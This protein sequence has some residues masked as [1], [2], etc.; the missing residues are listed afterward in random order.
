MSWIRWLRKNNT[1]VMAVVVIVLM[2]AFI[3]GSSL[4]Y[5]LRGRGGWNKPLAYY[6]ENNKITP[7]DQNVARQEL[8]ILRALRAPALLQSQD[9][10]GILLGELLFAESRGSPAVINYV[11]R[12]ARTNQ[13]RIS[14]RQIY[15]IYGRTMP[16]DMYWLLLKNE[17][18]LAGMHLPSKDVAELMGRVIPHL[19]EGKT[20]S[21]VMTALVNQFGAAEQEILGTLGKLLAVLQYAYVACSMEDVTD[22][23]TRHVA[24]YEGET[25]DAEFVRFDP[26]LFAESGYSPSEQDI[27]AQFDKHKNYF[28]GEVS[29]ENP[30]GF[31]YKLPD[32]I[33]LEYIAVKLDDVLPRIAVPTEEESEEYY[34]KNRDR[35]FTEQVSEDPN[36]P[37]SPKVKRTKGYAEVAGSISQ[38]LLRDRVNTKAEQILQDARGLT[39]AALAGATVEDAN[40]TVE[41]LKKLAGDYGKA[42][43]QVSLKHGVKVYSG[44][45]GLLSAV[46][47][48]MDE[49]LSKL[50][51][52]TLGYNPV[53]LSQIIFS[54]EG[55]EQ[56]HPRPLFVQKTRMYESIGPA[57][58]P[59]GQLKKDTSGQ[60]VAMVRVTDIQQACEPESINVSFSTKTF[61]LGT[62]AQTEDASSPHPAATDKKVFSVREKVIDDLKRLAALDT[63]KS[64]ATEFSALAKSDGW[65]KALAKFNETYE[66][67]AFTA[68]GKDG[69]ATREPNEPNA[70]RLETLSGLQRVSNALMERVAAQSAGNPAVNVMLNQAK[71][72]G[73][74]IDQLYSLVPH[75]SNTVKE[76]PLISE[77]KP[78][79][80]FYCVKS[81]TVRRLNEE[82]YESV[83]A[84][85]ANR[86]DHIQSQSLA[87]VHFNPDNIAKRMNFRW[88]KEPIRPVASPPINLEDEL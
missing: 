86:E 21:Q 82:E 87:A 69:Q 78:N 34:R 64:R 48:Q 56:A 59:L 28:P 3:G 58:D 85:L 57:K 79:L 32:R 72:E 84:R 74:F 13:Y 10:R 31:G 19:F 8:D 46:D 53:R 40:T 27:A 24:S 81:I 2:I 42:A 9:L 61:E 25:I 76:T 43:E 62:P 51:V 12:T 37:N 68:S 66:K 70:F 67:R 36:D 60:I 22:A 26:N 30:H 73:L 50:F 1:K 75:D 45:T 23:E 65:D 38:G 33:Q 44:Q 16:S 52:V 14:D 54:V 18:E 39:D 47:M 6:G 11:Q 77:F 7:Y 35:L 4:T 63:T 29:G 80:S 17:A 15:D 55:L 88:A 20:Y 83:K 71:A 41:E 5:L 49:Q